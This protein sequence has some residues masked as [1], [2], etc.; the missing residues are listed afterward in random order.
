MVIRTILRFHLVAFALFVSPLEAAAPVDD[1]LAALE[2]ADVVVEGPA[3]PKQTVYVFFDPNCW[4]CNLTWKALQPYERQGLQVRWVPVAYQK[5]SSAT[6]V[7]A[8]FG[9]KD[10]LE[11]FRKNERH[12]HEGSY[13]G[14]IQPAR[15][16]TPKLAAALTANLK[17]MQ[18][19]GAPGTPA[20]VWRDGRGS[21]RVKVGRPS[22]A[23]L[24]AIARGE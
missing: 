21:T 13:D 1:D 3:K 6:R 11:A 14:G 10:R 12:Y 19:L 9:A 7:A 4:Y 17:L 8:I 22:N 15:V 16:V 23:E 18:R 2:K 5:E 24:E 20:L